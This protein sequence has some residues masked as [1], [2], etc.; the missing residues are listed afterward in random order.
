MD[1]ALNLILSIGDSA[2]T[3][4]FGLGF[5]V[6]AATM[7]GGLTKIRKVANTLIATKRPFNFTGLRVGAS[8]D[9]IPPFRLLLLLSLLAT[10]YAIISQIY[11]LGEVSI[12]EKYFDVTMKVVLSASVVITYLK[13][14]ALIRERANG[15]P[16]KLNKLAVQIRSVLRERGIDI[17]AIGYAGVGVSMISLLPFVIRSIVAPT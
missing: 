4:Y 3:G 14:R 12:F 8:D 2:L 13:I 16:R 15:D 11:G 6:Y 5:S 9:F 10:F 7:E 1:A 17:R